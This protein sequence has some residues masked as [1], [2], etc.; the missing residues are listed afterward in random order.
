MLEHVNETVSVISS[1]NQEKNL[2][3]PYKMRWRLRDYFIEKLAYHHKVRE[4]R[5][6]FHIFHV[7][8]GNL[9]FR[10]RLDTESLSWMLEEV[11]DGS[12]D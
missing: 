1:Y 6:L 12:T 7:T 10:L 3:M 4:G 8:D 5:N 11:S 2:A 9:D